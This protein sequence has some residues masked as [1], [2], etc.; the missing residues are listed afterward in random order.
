[1]G[2]VIA[3]SELPTYLRRL[4]LSDKGRAT[5]LDSNILI[6]ATYDV[7]D[8]YSDV[9]QI[10]TVL[11][12]NGYR[13][14]ATVNTKAEYL[15]YRR[16]IIL[17]EAILDAVDEYSKLKFPKR[18]RAKISTLKGSLKTAMG[19]DPERDFVFGDVQLKKIKKE[20][21]AGP[22]SG[23]LG[24]LELCAD[25]LSGRLQELAD[26]LQNSGIEYVSQHDRSQSHLF[27]TKIDWPNAMGISEKTGASFSD[28][29]ILN[30]FQCSHCPFIVSMDFDVG[31][32]VLADSRLKDAVV[33]DRLAAEYRHYHFK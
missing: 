7:R 22:H 30:A 33:P 31:Y 27:H 29:M 25:F 17:T 9:R 28:S 20:I 18:A 5:I 10:L 16:R 2:R 15:E 4:N 11:E 13:L 8:E 23:Q 24:W 1:M 6:T 21:S 3:F 14:F 12:E 19:A 26:D 32:A